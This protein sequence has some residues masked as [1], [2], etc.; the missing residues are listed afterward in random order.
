MALELAADALVEAENR[1]IAARERVRAVRRQMM[2]Q[3]G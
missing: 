1:Y 3:H 2:G